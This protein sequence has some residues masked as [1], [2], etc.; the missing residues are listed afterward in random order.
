MS[1]IS[2]SKTDRVISSFNVPI[3]ESRVKVWIQSDITPVVKEKTGE[4]FIAEAIVLNESSGFTLIIDRKHLNHNTIG[5]EVYH[6]T[7]GITKNRYI[8]DEEASA[9]LNGY[10][11]EKVYNIVEKY[12]EKFK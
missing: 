4:D 11:C 1:E 2:L 8:Q 12:K 5:H 9:W 7:S 3:Y 10:L 6:I